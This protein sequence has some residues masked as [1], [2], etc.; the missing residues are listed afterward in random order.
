MINRESRRLRV[1]QVGMTRNLGGIETY[2]I[3]QF[4][5]LDKSKIDY[6]FVN[7]TG[8]YSICYEDEILASGSNEFLRLFLEHKNPLAPLL[9]VV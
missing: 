2:L 9:A 8:E 6:D 4:R 3:E 5:H 7:I 1:L